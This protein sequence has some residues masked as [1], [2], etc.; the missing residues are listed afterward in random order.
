MDTLSPEERSKRMSKVRSKNTGP[1]LIVRRL[2]HALGY[3]Y[4]L[5]CKTVVGHPDIVFKGRRKAVFVHGC[6]WHRH[7]G[8]PNCRLPKSRLD[9]WQPKLTANQMRDSKIQEALRQ[10]GWEVVVV[11]E[12][13]TRDLGLL[14]TKLTQFLGPPKRMNPPKT[15]R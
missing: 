8:C 1:E 12:C 4:R 11:W 9:F 2:L 10:L 13:E 5:Y 6:F 7:E 3:R 15:T 14:Q